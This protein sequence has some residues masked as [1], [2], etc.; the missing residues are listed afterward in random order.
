MAQ[1]ADYACVNRSRS[2]R[3][4]SDETIAYTPNKVAVAKEENE[5][6]ERDGGDGDGQ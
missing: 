3:T 6:I 1:L 2:V 4:R 5:K